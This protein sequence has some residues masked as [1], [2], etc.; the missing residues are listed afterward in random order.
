MG[1]SVVGVPYGPPMRVGLYKSSPGSSHGL[2][3]GLR[4]ATKA[5]GR[6]SNYSFVSFFG[7]QG[8]PISRVEDLKFL[9]VLGHSSRIDED[10][11][12]ECRA[13]STWGLGSALGLGFRV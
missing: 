2:L 7:G 4:V 3:L 11:A 5:N 13:W 6:W 1:A 12:P 8:I 10:V 9:G